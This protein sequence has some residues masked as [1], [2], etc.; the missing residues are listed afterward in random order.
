MKKL[1]KEG[2]KLNFEINNTSF[3]TV[4]SGKWKSTKVA[5]KKLLLDEASIEDVKKSMQKE[6]DVL[7]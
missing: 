2:N 4:Y 3:S 1:V 6:M 5:V 7:R